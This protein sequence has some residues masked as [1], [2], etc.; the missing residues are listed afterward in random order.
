MWT[1]VRSALAIEVDQTGADERHP[2][3][4]LARGVS[5]CAVIFN[6]QQG[7][8]FGETDHV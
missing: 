8:L 2:E 3:S 1:A 7:K 4:R 6:R 5:H